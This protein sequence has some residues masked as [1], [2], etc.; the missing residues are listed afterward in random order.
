MFTAVTLQFYYN[1]FLICFAYVPTIFMSTALC[2]GGHTVQLI[3][4]KHLATIGKTFRTNAQ[5]QRLSHL[6]CD[7][8]MPFL[9]P[10]TSN[11]HVLFVN[12]HHTLYFSKYLSW[13]WHSTSCFWSTTQSFFLNITLFE[14]LYLTLG[15]DDENIGWKCCSW[16]FCKLHEVWILKTKEHYSIRKY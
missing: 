4:G 7:T 16:E 2:L 12:I 1:H 5:W 9:A 6:E 8:V 10:D 15:T 14:I 11:L 13:L 3:L